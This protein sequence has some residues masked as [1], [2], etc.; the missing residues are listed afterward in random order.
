MHGMFLQSSRRSHQPSSKI[1]IDVHQQLS[2]SSLYQSAPNTASR[3]HRCLPPGVLRSHL[4]GGEGLR[5]C[6]LPLLVSRAVPGPV[7]MFTAS[8]AMH[9][10]L[11]AVLCEVTFNITPITGHI[12]AR[13]A[14]GTTMG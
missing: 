5:L 4:G 13:A 2:A 14:P 1:G 6:I 9:F 3:Q 7:S 11:S 10:A 12:G 8:V